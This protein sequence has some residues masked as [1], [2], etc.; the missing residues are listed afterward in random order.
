MRMRIRAVP[1]IKFTLD[2][3]IAYS[4][5]IAE[6]LNELHKSD[7]NATKPEDEAEQDAKAGEE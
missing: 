1:S 5:R 4:V 2:N 6:I 3:T 7:A